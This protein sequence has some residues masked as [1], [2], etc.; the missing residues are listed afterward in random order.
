MEETDR[1]CERPTNQG[2]M[3]VLDTW[4]NGLMGMLSTSVS[5]NLSDWTMVI[6]WNKP[7]SNLFGYYYVE[8]NSLETPEK[9]FQ[10]FEPTISN[11]NININ[12]QQSVGLIFQPNYSKFNIVFLSDFYEIECCYW[13]FMSRV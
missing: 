12:N 4:S 1:N 3:T 6:E 11:T 8:E 9:C 10:Y 2:V 13:W 5:G 7:V